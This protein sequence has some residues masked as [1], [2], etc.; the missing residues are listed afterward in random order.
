MN[1]GERAIRAGASIIAAAFAVSLG[2][3][4]WYAIPAGLCAAFLAVG[5]ITGWC[6]SAPA[7]TCVTTN[8]H[9]ILGT[10]ESRPTA[11]AGRH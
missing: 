1:A 7:A 11:T 4:L 3:N 8:Q 5:A 9:A 2:E 10:T 6:N